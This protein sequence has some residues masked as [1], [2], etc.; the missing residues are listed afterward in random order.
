MAYDL[1]GILTGGAATRSDSISG[2]DPEYR[3]VLEAMMAAAPPDIAKQLN[4]MSGYRSKELQQQL[5][6]NALKKYG[7][8]SAARKWVAPPGRSQ[9]GTGRAI[10]WKYASPEARQW[11]RDNAAHFGAVFPLANEPWHMELAGARNG[12]APTTGASA[13]VPAQAGG[14][15]LNSAG[16]FAPSPDPVPSPVAAT[17][18]P[19]ASNP[20]ASILG[21]ISGGSQGSSGGGDD[22]STQITPSSISQD[23]GS[24]EAA[25]AAQLMSV[26]MADRRKRYGL[27]LTGMG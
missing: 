1:S 2:L 21:A 3:A 10:D 22:A 18:A 16:A 20:L 26:L 15:T 17:G 8:E 7:S 6:N 5:W 11:V 12:K 4:I 13:A 14:V 9:H 19:A 23:T 27:S 25:Q 24:E